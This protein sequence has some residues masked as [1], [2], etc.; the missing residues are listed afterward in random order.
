MFA[1]LAFDDTHGDASPGS[2]PQAGSAGMLKK[3]KLGAKAA[4]LE[5]VLALCAPEERPAHFPQV[6]ETLRAA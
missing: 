2:A 5:D 1:D 3:A 6:G 4:D